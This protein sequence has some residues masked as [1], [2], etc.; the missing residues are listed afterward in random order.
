MAGPPAF[1]PLFQPAAAPDCEVANGRERKQPR[2]PSA[3]EQSHPPRFES[4]A[5]RRPLLCRGASLDLEPGESGS[6]SLYTITAQLRRRAE[7]D[8]SLDQVGRDRIRR[9]GGHHWRSPLSPPDFRTF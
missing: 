9:N 1:G 5:W 7:A 8:V 6:G 3:L 2:P 4:I